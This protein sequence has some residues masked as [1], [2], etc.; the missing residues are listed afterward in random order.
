M[1]AECSNLTK[2][3]NCLVFLLVDDDLRFLSSKANPRMPVPSNMRQAT[4]G[5]SV[6][7]LVASSETFCCGWLLVQA[8]TMLPVI[9]Q[10]PNNK[11]SAIC[12][13]ANDPPP[14][15]MSGKEKLPVTP[16]HIRPKAAALNVSPLPR[17]RNKLSAASV[18]T[19]TLAPSMI[20]YMLLPDLPISR[21]MVCPLFLRETTSALPRLEVKL[22]ALLAVVLSPLSAFKL[23]LAIVCCP[24]SAAESRVSSNTK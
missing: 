8:V 10:S 9:T 15:E 16:F 12:S 19:F 14:A 13:A 11:L 20:Q 3:G 4:S 7:A 17:I 24:A 18:L 5:T 22:S 23:P 2:Q 21:L 1:F 6:P